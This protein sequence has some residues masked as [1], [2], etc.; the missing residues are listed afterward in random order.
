M[1]EGNLAVELIHPKTIE[2]CLIAFGLKELNKEVEVI[3]TVELIADICTRI[4]RMEDY[5]QWWNSDEG[6]EDE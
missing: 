6:E 5:V 1:R 3:L 2:Q 4:I